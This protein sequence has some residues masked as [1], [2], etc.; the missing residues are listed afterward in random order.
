MVGSFLDAASVITYPHFWVLI[1]LDFLL[2]QRACRWNSA[3]HLVFRGALIGGI[4][5]LGQVDLRNDAHEQSF[6]LALLIGGGFLFDRLATFAI[7]QPWRERHALRGD[8]L[9]IAYLPVLASSAIFG[10]FVFFACFGFPHARPLGIERSAKIPPDLQAHQAGR[11]TGARDRGG[12]ASRQV[13][14]SLE[15]ESQLR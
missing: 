4:S 2:L 14:P 1:A 6:V 13:G 3:P 12:P 5:M 10:A 7:P 8:A 15:H 11:E 9:K